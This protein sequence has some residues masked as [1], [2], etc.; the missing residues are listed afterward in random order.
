MHAWLGR[1]CICFKRGEK[2]KP[3]ADSSGG[4]LSLSKKKGFGVEIQRHLTGENLG[5]SIHIRQANLAGLTNFALIYME[6]LAL[7]KTIQC[8]CCRMSA[9]FTQE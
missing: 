7:H 4:G 2:T 6:A 5:A 8:L 1:V 9:N 3:L